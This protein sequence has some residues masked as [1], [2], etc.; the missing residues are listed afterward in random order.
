MLRGDFCTAV[1]LVAAAFFALL[2]LYL[3]GQRGR[4]RTSTE[5]FLRQSGFGPNAL[6]GYVYL[7]WI[8]TYIRT[9]LRLPDPRTSQV[10]A[11]GARW[12]A[13]RYHGKVLTHEHSREIIL[14]NR[15]IPLQDLEQIVPYPV[16]RNLVLHGSPEVVAFECVCRHVRPVHCEPTRVCM[17]IG[18]PFTDFTLE[19]HPNDSHRLTQ[20]EAL[21]LL[22]AEHQRGHVHSAW[23]KDAM[24]G[25]FY[26]ICNCCKCCCGGIEKMRQGVRMMEGS[27]YVA[28]IDVA[29]CANCGDCL[30]ACPFGALS[31]REDGINRDW[32]LCMGCGVCEVTCAAGAISLARDVSK[33]V[34]L[35][36]RGTAG[37]TWVPS[38]KV[39]DARQP[40]VSLGDTGRRDAC[41]VDGRLPSRHVD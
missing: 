16:A 22:E 40:K 37:V 12:L 2:F 5:E 3:L 26:A 21:E 33:G 4:I 31:V 30:E 38:G 23:F 18:K 19:H 35:D 36:V 8:T 17:V 32:D 6:H 20:A 28:E 1:V 7:R 14:L 29:Q 27:G 10:A 34:P 15:E 41:M 25:R 39:I 24:L 9:L 13:Q 11:L